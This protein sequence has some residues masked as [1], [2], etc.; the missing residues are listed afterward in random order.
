MN[1]IRSGRW[2]LV[3]DSE[4]LASKR[5][6]GNNLVSL[7]SKGNSEHAGHFILERYAVDDDGNICVT[8]CLSISELHGTLDI[9]KAELQALLEE[10]QHRFPDPPKANEPVQALSDWGAM[11]PRRD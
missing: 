6:R 9:I 2:G 4:S 10:A 3:L 1:I 5:S 7:P 11:T 8:P